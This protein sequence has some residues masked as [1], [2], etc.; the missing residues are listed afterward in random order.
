MSNKNK[1]EWTNPTT[2]EKFVHKE[3]S[4]GSTEFLYGPKDTPEEK[5]HGHAE[6]DSSGNVTFNRDPKD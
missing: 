6:I 5:R 3:R 4:D 1:I 2:G